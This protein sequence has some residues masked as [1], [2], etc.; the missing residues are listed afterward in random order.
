[1][2]YLN[3]RGTPFFL[4]HQPRNFDYVTLVSR[5]KEHFRKTWVLDS[6][7]KEV[8]NEVS[9]APKFSAQM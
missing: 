2:E 9:S 3:P 5:R 6:L 1:M 7:Q 8:F 4:R